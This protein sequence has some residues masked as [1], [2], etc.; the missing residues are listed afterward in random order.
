LT[1][2]NTQPHSKYHAPSPLKTVAAAVP[3]RSRLFAHATCADGYEYFGWAE[4]IA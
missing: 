1:C 4:F 3:S 2:A